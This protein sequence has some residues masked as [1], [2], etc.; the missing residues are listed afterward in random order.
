MCQFKNTIIILRVA[1]ETGYDPSPRILGIEAPQNSILSLGE[2][3]KLSEGEEF[4]KLTPSP[5]KGERV[6]FL[7]EQSEFRNSGEGD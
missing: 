6:E 5:Y 1:P 2:D 3:E 7:N 4:I